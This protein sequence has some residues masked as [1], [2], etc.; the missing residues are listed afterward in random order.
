VD[1]RPAPLCDT[2][3]T[4]VAEESVAYAPGDAPA[5]AHLRLRAVDGLLVMLTFA[6]ALAI[7]GAH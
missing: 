5:P 7:L 2:L 1:L 3:V 4:W 6:P